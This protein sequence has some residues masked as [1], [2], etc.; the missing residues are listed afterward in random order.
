MNAIRNA[1]SGSVKSFRMPTLVG[2]Q[3]SGN[4]LGLMRLTMPQFQLSD[5]ETFKVLRAALDAGVN[6]WN[7]ADFYGTP[8][9]NTLHL[10]N[11]Y[12]SKYPEDADKVIL[13]IKSGLKDRATMEMDCTPEGL[14][15]SVDN[16]IS[17]LDGKK[18]IDIFGLARVDPNTPIEDSVK[19]LL[20]LKEEGK[21]KGIQITEVRAETIRRAA[22]VGKVDMVE[23]EASL[24]SPMVFENGVAQAC[25][26]NDIVLVAHTPLGMGALTG[27][28]KKLD[29]IPKENPIRYVPRYQPDVFENNVKLVNA[30]EK[31]AQKKGCTTT[32]LALNYLKQ[33]SK[34]SGMPTVIPIAGARAEERVK[35]NA[36]DVEISEEEFKEIESYQK[37]FPIEGLRTMPQ[38]QVRNE[39]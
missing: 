36:V 3:I 27:Q 12:F 22:S 4:G 28:F 35:Q 31:L 2:K 21:F 32:Q 24:W 13:S 19:G 33:Q 37:E 39:Y 30:V 6:V 18:E 26:E 11:R 14:R 17:I 5:D 38:L 1:V 7:G 29:D 23:A 16:A 9:A 20:A 8:Q 34:R 10:L 25:A 15:K